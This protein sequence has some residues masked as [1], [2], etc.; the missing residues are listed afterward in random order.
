MATDLVYRISAIDNASKVAQRVQGSFSKIA[1]PLDKMTR[2]LV[3]TG[4]RG[5][6][7]L[8]RVETGIRSIATVARTASDRIAS[9]VPGLAAVTGLLSVAGVGALAD[10][11]ANFGFSLQNTSRQLGMSAQSLQAWHYAAKRAGV[12]AAAFDQS[13]VSSQDT[14]RSAAFGANPQAMMLMNRLGVN[15]SRT[16]SGDINYQKTQQDLL[17]ALS[18]IKNPAGQRTAADALGLGAL[19]PMIQRGSFNVDRQR[20]IANLY[21]PGPEAIERARIFHDRM[22]DVTT[23]ASALANAIGDKLTPVLQPMVEQF[24][25][26]LDAHR[27][28]V[29]NRLADA[30][31]KFTNWITSVD[32]G[33]IYD[34]VNSVVDKFGG[35]GSVLRD[36]VA[37]KLGSV[38]I[39]WLAPI[40]SLAASLTATATAAKAVKLAAG[41]GAAA[42]GGA[43]GAGSGVAAGAATGVG[44]GGLLAS[45]FGLWAATSLVRTGGLLYSSNLNVGEDKTLAAIHA[46]A[47]K[48]SISA[49]KAYPLGSKDPAVVAAV[50]RFM[51]RGWTAQQASGIVANLMQE[52]HMNPYA[53]GDNGLA[54]GIGQWHLDRQDDFKRVFGH[55]I[56]E[57]TLDEQ[58]KF[59]D[60]ELRSGKRMTRDAGGMLSNANSAADAGA[61]VSRYD[62][63]PRDTALQMSERGKL[64]QE[65]LAGWQSANGGTGTGQ[66]PVQVHV[67]VSAPPGT[68]VD[69][70]NADG[71]G[72][73]TRVNYQ[74]LGAMP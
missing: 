64:A 32:W 63:R 67:N 72:V 13:M 6:V 34:K 10:R 70:S 43:A 12:T 68:R 16:K 37:I 33:G 1:S 61:I 41:A 29:A 22:V 44:I 56:R 25:R 39:S 35:W 8:A 27:V 46:G 48:R 30:V 47:G 51:A 31:Q 60:W 19:L 53:V 49:S 11:W 14:I 2:G 57:S 17:T 5:T 40:A 24:T 28:E 42:A 54:Y 20:G 62:L 7:A 58:E 4:R 50:N 52:S 36:I 73:P 74:M 23:S 66:A 65:V 26:W 71:S 9:I 3:D 59:F 38:V 18:R 55:D 69:A 45:P 21:A 15:I